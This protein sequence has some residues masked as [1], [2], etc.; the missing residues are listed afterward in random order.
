MKLTVTSTDTS[1]KK[2]SI[3]VSDSSF[4]REYHE[5]LVHQVV[6]AYLAGGRQ[7]SAAQKSRSTARGGGRK[8]WRQKR[9]GRARAGTIRSP[10]WRGGGVT[11]AAS[12]R[13]YSQKVNRKMYRAAM[14]SILSELNRTG[15]LKVIDDITPEAPKTRHLVKLLG[16]FEN[17]NVKDPLIVHHEPGPN[18]I[19]SARNLPGVE[20]C[21]ARQVNPYALL[22]HES[23]LMT[24]AAL[25]QIEEMLA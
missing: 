9:L 10:I 13:D 23:V 19:L 8:P 22:A 12:P 25:R 1:A 7:G 5:S 24:E 17:E 21:E 6:V 14:R 20:V 11:F 3:E 18:L 4:G 16:S 2:R 15:R